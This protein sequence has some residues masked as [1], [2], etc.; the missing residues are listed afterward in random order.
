MSSSSED[1]QDSSEMLR[2][3]P[4]K[5]KVHTNPRIPAG[6]RIVMACSLEAVIGKGTRDVVIWDP[7]ACVPK[8][9][10]KINNLLDEADGPEAD[11]ETLCYLVRGP[12]GVTNM[13]KVD[14]DIRNTHVSTSAFTRLRTSGARWSL[15]AWT[16][17]EIK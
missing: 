13:K 16:R 1:D 9:I 4:P 15:R 3:D 7:K 8:L 5:D 6:I 10:D 2:L 12:E 14:V 17:I 11:D